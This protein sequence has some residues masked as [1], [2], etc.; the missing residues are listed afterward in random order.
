MPKGN[1]EEDLK[2]S[3]FSGPQIANANAQ[4]PRQGIE[5]VT[6]IGGRWRA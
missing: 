3:V 1:R 5:G 4:S 2:M 6:A